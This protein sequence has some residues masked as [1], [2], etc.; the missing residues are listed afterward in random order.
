M[1][2]L[3]NVMINIE[4]ATTIV[5]GM[6]LSLIFTTSVLFLQQSFD[7]FFLP[8]LHPL[9]ANMKLTDFNFPLQ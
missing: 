5:V 4:G 8:Q 6:K 2:E 7:I 1:L 3:A 9:L